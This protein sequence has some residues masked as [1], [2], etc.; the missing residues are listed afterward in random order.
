M[1]NYL[2]F[3]NL[4]GEVIMKKLPSV[5]ELV[6]VNNLPDATLYRVVETNGK[7]GVGL[8]DSTIEKQ[9]PNQA[10]QWIDVGVVKYPK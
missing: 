4:T 10:T 1:K 8:I 7:F 5:G 2:L 9:V 3:F 6:V